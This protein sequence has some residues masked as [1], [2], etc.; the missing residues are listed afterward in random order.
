MYIILLTV[1]FSQVSKLSSIASTNLSI[2]YSYNNSDNIFLEKSV[3]YKRILKV[4]YFSCHA[5]FA[6][7]PDYTTFDSLLLFLNVLK[8]CLP[9][10]IE[11]KVSL[12]FFKLLFFVHRFS[13]YPGHYNKMLGFRQEEVKNCRICIIILLLIL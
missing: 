5:C 2:H 9:C 8:Y 13:G 6:N 11:N 4:R 1:S 3:L 7:L 12:S 10:F